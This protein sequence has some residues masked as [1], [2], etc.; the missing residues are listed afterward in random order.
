MLL[1]TATKLREEVGLHLVDEFVELTDSNLTA[2]VLLTNPSGITRRVEQ[3]TEIGVGSPIEVV[4]PPP[5]PTR[6]LIPGNVELPTWNPDELLCQQNPGVRVVT[7]T[8]QRKKRLRELL[9]QE[10]E[11]MSIP[12]AEKD[13]LWSLLEEYHDVFS[14][15]GERGGT[16]LVE[17]EINT[18]DAAPKRQPPRRVPFAVWQEIAK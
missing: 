18:G 3:G 13:M 16:N 8:Q 12:V 10:F 9:K 14:L 11:D 7:S 15:D 1:E 6:V 4:E 5:Q 17:L 2:K